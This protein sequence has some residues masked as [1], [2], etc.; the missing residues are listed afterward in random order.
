MEEAWFP[1]F[2]QIP[3]Q[4]AGRFTVTLLEQDALLEMVGN[5]YGGDGGDHKPMDMARN[6]QSD[7]SEKDQELTPILAI[8]PSAHPQMWLEI[9]NPLL[10]L[11]NLPCA[12]KKNALATDPKLL[13]SAGHLELSCMSQRHN[14]LKLKLQLR[15]TE[16]IYC[17]SN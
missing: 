17:Q 9:Q 16:S 2:S 12:L 3:S 1:L 5:N 15:I 10:R 13:Q 7:L 4:G 8:F 6:A 11:V 14:H